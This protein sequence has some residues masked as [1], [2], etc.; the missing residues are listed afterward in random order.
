MTKEELKEYCNAEFKNID[1]VIEELFSIVS[2]D[3]SYTIAEIAAIATFMLNAYNGIENILKEMLLFDKLEVKDSP[4]WH[5][6]VIK[7]AAEL[8]IL[9]PDLY[10]N[11]S[12]HLSFRR[13]FVHTY[14]FNMKLEE[15]KMLV[16]GIK[17][18][19]ARF[20]SEVDEYIQVI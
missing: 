11:L 3:K 18:I 12:T 9:P 2:P 20:K 10:Q 14:I 7:K 1:R 16:D 13:F 4:T 19:I 17:G 6:E 15:L 8:G 5:E